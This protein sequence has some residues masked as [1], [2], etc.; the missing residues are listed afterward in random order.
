MGGS[1]TP[2]AVVAV[3]HS[4]PRVR[5]FPLPRLLEDQIHPLLDTYDSPT[6][7]LGDLT[8]PPG[9]RRRSG[10]YMTAQSLG[11]LFLLLL[12]GDTIAQ[13]RASLPPTSHLAQAV[14]D[15]LASH[16]AWQV[17][18]DLPLILLVD[19]HLDIEKI[20]EALARQFKDHQLRYNA[21]N[22]SNDMKEELTQW[23]DAIN[24]NLLSMELRHVLSALGEPRLSDMAQ[25]LHDQHITTVR[26]VAYGYLCLLPLP[27]VL[28]TIGGVDGLLG[29]HFIMTIAPSARLLDIV[30]QRTRLIDPDRR[31]NILAVG[32]PRRTDAKPLQFAEAETETLKTTVE[33][34]REKLSPEQYQAHGLSKIIVLNGLSATK[35]A[36]V[37]ELGQAWLGWLA[38][39]GKYDLIDPMNCDDVITVRECF[40]PEKHQTYDIDLQGM[41]LLVLSACEQA[42]FD[43]NRGA[44][45]MVGMPVSLFHAGIAGVVAPLWAVDDRATYL[46]MS[47]FADLYLDPAENHSPAQALALAQ[48]WL[49]EMN[50]GEVVHYV[51]HWYRQSHGEERRML[52]RYLRHYRYLAEQ[53]P[54]LQPFA[55]PYYWAA[56]TCTGV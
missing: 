9:Y 33:H 44:D 32:N 36:V 5:V 49:R 3:M 27:A 55:H 12:W 28:V 52:F 42:L 2:G 11:S 6:V 47:R 25:W 48:K 26:V 45:E 17:L 19:Q 54:D 29:E 20:P 24:R 53:N 31:P 21:Y 37:P 46:L 4:A 30:K 40:F 51:E 10:G 43:F 15:A 18:L 35:A 1:L 56:F 50:M 16:P 41:C 38:T 13:A 23:I 7:I 39:H 34:L 22:V 8:L 14:E